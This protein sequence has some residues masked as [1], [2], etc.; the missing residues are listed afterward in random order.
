MCSAQPR[1]M[2]SEEKRL[3]WMWFDEDGE[4]AAEI[5]SR[6]RRDPTTIR[7]F[8]TH[9]NIISR[10]K[11]RPRALGEQQIDR[12]VKLVNA[13]VQ[14]AGGKY[15]VTLE[16]IRKR[17]RPKVCIRVLANALHQR[18]VWFHKL[19][20]KPVLTSEDVRARSA[21]ATRYRSRTAAWWAGQVHLHVDSHVFKVPGNKATRRAL[22]A[23]KVHGAYRTVGRGLRPEH[24]KQRLLFSVRSVTQQP[25]DAALRVKSSSIARS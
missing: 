4:D 3:A 23:R 9:G 12:L 13:E 1:Y 25:R 24:V 14:K 21:F 20:E 8:L 16:F 19:R 5:A 10:R 7:R 22:A 15:A 11:E 6:L 2:T 17:S 18:G